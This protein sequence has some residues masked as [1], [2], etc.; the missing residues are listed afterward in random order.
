M[1]CH[2]IANRSGTHDPS[3][4]TP[5]G[6]C[7]IGPGPIRYP[8]ACSVTCP[9]RRCLSCVARRGRQRRREPPRQTS[10][11]RCCRRAG[12]V[13]DSRGRRAGPRR[14]ASSCSESLRPAGR[15]GALRRACRADQ[16]YELFVNGA[17]RWPPDRRAA[18]WITGGSRRWTSRRSCAAGRN[19]IAAIVWNFGAEAPM[20]QI[21]FETGFMLQGDGEAE[22]VV[23]T[24]R[25]GSR[26]R[27]RRSR[28]CR[29]TARPSTT[30]ISSAGPARWWTRA[31]SVGLGAAGLRRQPL[32]RRRHDHAGGPR[33][34]RD[35]PSRWF[36]VPRGIPLM[37]DT[38]ERIEKVVRTSGGDVPAGVLQ[39]TAAWTIARATRV[40]SCWIAAI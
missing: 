10:I 19:V 28:C 22:A 16:R 8:H 6:P 18:I 11:R 12:R 5:P 31:V 20:A 32:D 4:S 26:P 34:A 23:N 17:A 15:A 40:T 33:G 37:E 1:S 27:T 29:S 7:N 35:S 24:A 39:G 38:P 3:E 2:G 25:P 9:R 21:S 14:S 30:S 13:L 36:L